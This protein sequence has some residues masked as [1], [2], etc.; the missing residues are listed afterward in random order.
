[1]PDKTLSEDQLVSKL[2]ASWDSITIKQGG[3]LLQLRRYRKSLSLGSLLT[4]TLRRHFLQEAD[5][6]CQ[7]LLY[8][9]V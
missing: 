7:R 2:V 8:S 5:A 9:R 3:R 4:A 6:G 1:M